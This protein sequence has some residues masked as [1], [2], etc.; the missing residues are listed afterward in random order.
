[1]TEP[2]NQLLLVVLA[3]VMAGTIST[4][5]AYTRRWPNLG[6]WLL[7]FMLLGPLYWLVPLAAGLVARDDR[8]ADKRYRWGPHTGDDRSDLGGQ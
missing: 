3:W 5:V 8:G 6:T 4:A 2:P 7:V 1:V